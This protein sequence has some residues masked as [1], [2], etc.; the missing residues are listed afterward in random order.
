MGL[1]LAS[2]WAAPKAE[3]SAGSLASCSVESSGHRTAEHSAE[4]WAALTAER[5]VSTKVSLWAL[6]LA[7]PKAGR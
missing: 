7:A 1:Q 5:R 3:L 2:H 4:K 6:H